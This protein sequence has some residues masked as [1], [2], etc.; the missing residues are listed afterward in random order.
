MSPGLLSLQSKPKQLGQKESD[1]S[2]SPWT[3]HIICF[4]LCSL[5]PESCNSLV[6]FPLRRTAPLFLHPL[7]AYC[8]V[9]TPFLSG[10]FFCSAGNSR[11]S[12]DVVSFFPLCDS[13]S[14]RVFRFGY[15][16]FP[17]RWRERN[18]DWRTSSFF[19][20]LFSTCTLVKR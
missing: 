15:L 4:R 9:R 10:F 7:L 19:L 13:Y 18:G 5:P 2:Q 12:P 16:F 20:F 11:P 6:F 1:K 8:T 17:S 3:F 14:S